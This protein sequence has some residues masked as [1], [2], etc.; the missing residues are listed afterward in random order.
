MSQSPLSNH[1]VASASEWLEARRALL[2]KEKAFSRLREQLAEERRALPWERVTKPYR[3]SAPSG[4]LSLAQLF[5]THRQLIVYHFMY[6]PG[7]QAGCAHCS[8]WADHFDG[9][10]QL[11]AFR[12][13]MGW[14][15]PWVSSGESDFNYDFQASFRPEARA[16]GQV[17]YN[18]ATGPAGPADREGI[19]VFYRG[20]GEELF[21]TYSCYARGIDMMNTTYQFLDLT[22]RGR[23]EP[24]GEAQYW[25]RHHDRY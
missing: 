22:P 9:M 13:R 3:F 19:S 10:P 12:A 6:A 21:H 14:R 1:P 20:A 25:V 7:A 17:F 8:F 23:D 15:F 4:E 24:P 5:G 16:S 18:Y 11:E 2:A